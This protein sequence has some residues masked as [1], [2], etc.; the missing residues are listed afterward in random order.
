[1]MKATARLSSPS[2]RQ[3]Y[4]SRWSLWR[5]GLASALVLGLCGAPAEAQETVVLVGTG[6]SVPVPLYNRWAQEYDKRNSKIQMRYVPMGSSEGIKQI[7]LAAE[8][9]PLARLCL[10]PLSK[11]KEV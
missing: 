4:F 1:M 2:I 11:G 7:S 3:P 6:S 10:P 9:L 5:I 8:I